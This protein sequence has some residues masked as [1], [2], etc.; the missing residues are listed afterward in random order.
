MILQG[1]TQSTDLIG[2]CWST[3][4]EDGESD[5]D[6]VAMWCSNFKNSNKWR[7]RPKQQSGEKVSLFILD[8]GHPKR[9]GR[10]REKNVSHN[11]LL[12]SMLLSSRA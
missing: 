5:M 1:P 7:T 6:W 8:Q 3:P 12:W 4:H 9:E 11:V 2:H 10:A